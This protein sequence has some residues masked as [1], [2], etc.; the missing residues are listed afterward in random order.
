MS[1]FYRLSITEL[2]ATLEVVV[3]FPDNLF[4]KNSEY[5]LERDLNEAATEAIVR[6]WIKLHP[7][8]ALP[9]FPS[10]FRFS[11]D[12]LSTSDVNGLTPGIPPYTSSSGARVW[13]TRPTSELALRSYE[14][15]GAGA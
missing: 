9:P 10:P 14:H 15:F 11:I 3:E 7:G 4:R 1:K 8:K 6:R 12:L 5:E 2:A 13:I